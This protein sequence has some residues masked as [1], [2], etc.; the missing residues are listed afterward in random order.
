[1]LNN[2]VKP[3]GSITEKI[4]KYG[5]DAFEKLKNKIADIEKAIEEEDHTEID[6]NFYYYF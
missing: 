6:P 1:M 2:N 3:A 4:I 5:K